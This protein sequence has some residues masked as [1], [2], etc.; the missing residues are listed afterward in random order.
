GLRVRVVSMPSWELF[1]EQPEDYKEQVLPPSVKRRLVVEA[2]QALGWEKYAGDE[3]AILGLDDFGR[4]GP[5][6]ELAEKYG[7][8]PGNV[9][10]RAR[11][12]M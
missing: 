9:A 8:T 2:G 7:F 10:A 4:S 1:E 3:G 12:L 5:W 6:K 11:E